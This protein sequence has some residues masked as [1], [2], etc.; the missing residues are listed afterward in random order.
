MR[1]SRPRNRRGRYLRVP[2]AA[3][4]NCKQENDE[5]ISD[6]FEFRTFRSPGPVR[7]ESL[8]ACRG[9]EC[10]IRREVF[11]A[12]MRYMTLCRFAPYG[13]GNGRNS[14]GGEL[15]VHRGGSQMFCFRTVHD[16][17]ADVFH[18]DSP[19]I[20]IRFRNIEPLK[21]VCHVTAVILHRQWGKSGGPSLSIAEILGA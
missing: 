18:G 20:E 15:P 19:G 13:G 3:V 11:S 21:E 6:K 2:Q 8:H 9:N 4:R 5:R 12:W 1:Y 7:R 16:P 17:F 10:G 14:A